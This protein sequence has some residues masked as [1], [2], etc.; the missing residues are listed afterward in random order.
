VSCAAAPPQKGAVGQCCGRGR[1]R[2]TG[3]YGCG[4][5]K[6]TARSRM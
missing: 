1:G 6:R 3:G 2:D 5:N 4:K